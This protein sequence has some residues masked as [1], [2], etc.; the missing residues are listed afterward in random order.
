MKKQVMKNSKI[1]VHAIGG[2]EQVGK[3]MTAIEY[4]DEIVIIDIGLYLDRYIALQDTEEKSGKRVTANQLIDAEAIPNDRILAKNANKVKA[5][6][7]GHAHLDHIGA[8]KWLAA[9]YKC[10]IIGSPYTIEVLKSILKDDKVSVPNK[11]TPLNLNSSIKITNNISIELVYVTHSILQAA[12]TVVHTPAGDVVYTPDFK[13]DDTPT[14]GQK[15]NMKRLRELGR[16]NVVALFVDCTNA[17]EERHTFSEA[18]ARDMLKDVLLG[19][20]NKN[21]AILVTTFSSHLPRLKSVIDFGR[22]IGREVVFVGR[23]LSKYIRAAENLGLVEFSKHARIV[24]RGKEIR[25]FLNQANKNRDKYLLAVTGNQGEPNAALARITRDEMPFNILPGDFIIFSC[26]V[27]PAPLIQANR[28]V[29]EQALRRKKARVFKNVHESGHA[30]REDLRDLIHIIRP[31][32]VIPAHGDMNK[33]ASCAELAA[34]LG[35]RLGKNT[36][37]LQNGQK[38][39]L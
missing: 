36:H 26:E 37:I 18:I 3:N 25:S 2:Y 27:I 28:R 14:I 17:Q 38:V 32:H 23:S 5:I 6:V 35:Y 8:I 10:P 24:G 20:D 19:I 7:L 13:F 12:I 34:E 16:G 11:L 39:V 1:T 33:L 9:K 15:T 29:V 31:Q 30:S 21:H 4:G 22:K